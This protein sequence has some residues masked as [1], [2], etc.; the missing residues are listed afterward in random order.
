M[1]KRERSLFKE[2][3]DLVLK[4][5]ELVGELTEFKPQKRHLGENHRGEARQFRDS[6]PSPGLVF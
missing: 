5:G 6:L 4:K 2:L 3:L 1:P